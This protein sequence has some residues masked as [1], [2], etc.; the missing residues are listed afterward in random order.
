VAFLEGAEHIYLELYLFSRHFLVWESI[1]FCTLQGL[2]FS[3]RL[4]STASNRAWT[5]PSTRCSWFSTQRS[6]DVTLFSKQ[7]AIAL[8]FLTGGIWD[9][10]E[11][12]YLL[13]LLV[14]PDCMRCDLRVSHL[15]NA[16]LRVILRIV[17][18]TQFNTVLHVGS[19]VSCHNFRSFCLCCRRWSR[20]DSSLFSSE[21]RS[22]RLD[23]L[24]AEPI[25]IALSASSVVSTWIREEIS[26]V[27]MFRNHP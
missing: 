23:S 10:K 5:W 20:P 2:A 1:S 19:L 13:V 6:C 21:S 4:S 17:L 18:V 27:A 16:F 11:H 12:E 14:Y 15:S 9:L 25:A 22:W 7:S 8:V 24:Y 3:G 26:S